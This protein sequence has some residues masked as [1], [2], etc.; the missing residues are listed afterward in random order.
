MAFTND[1]VQHCYCQY[2]YATT[3]EPPHKRCCKCGDRMAAQYAH[4][5]YL[6]KPSANVRRW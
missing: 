1:C 6:T 4:F 3:C 5:T 2:E